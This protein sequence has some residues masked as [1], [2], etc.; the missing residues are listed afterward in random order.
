MELLMSDLVLDVAMVIAVVQKQVLIIL[1]DKT[2]GK[3]SE[4]CLY[5]KRG[6]KYALL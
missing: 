4:F 2:S 6:K 5:G 1:V 3:L